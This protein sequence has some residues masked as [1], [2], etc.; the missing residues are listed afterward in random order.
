MKVFLP[1]PLVSYTQGRREIEAS[2]ATV[3]GVLSALES[4][5]PGLRFRIVD[6]QGRIREHI[7]FFVNETQ[8]RELSVPVAPSDEIHIIAA[9]SGG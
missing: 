9:L 5:Y 2:G 8:I 4:R 6:E 3:A 7:R 1:S